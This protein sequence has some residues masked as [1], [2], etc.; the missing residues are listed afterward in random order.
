MVIQWGRRNMGEVILAFIIF[1][2]IG[3]GLV[4]GWKHYIAPQEA[5]TDAF[6][7]CEFEAN[8]I[9]ALDIAKWIDQHSTDMFNPFRRQ[10]DAFIET[11]VKKEGWCSISDDS[12]WPASHPLMFAP[13]DP[14]A[15]WIYNY[16]Y[17]HGANSEC[18]D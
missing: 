3:L 9:F 2:A 14:V 7:Q 17:M 15:R 4:V 11:C 13:R 1:A 16:R 12:I 8:K 6:Y 5:V 18:H 10:R